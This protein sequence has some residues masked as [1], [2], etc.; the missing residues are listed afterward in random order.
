MSVKWIL[1]DVLLDSFT[2]CDGI[3][4]EDVNSVPS[5][6]TRGSPPKHIYVQIKVQG[7]V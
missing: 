1:R 6:I 4:P 7:A 2:L 5:L 3:R